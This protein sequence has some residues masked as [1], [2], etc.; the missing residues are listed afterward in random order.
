M[1]I[2][3]LLSILLFSIYSC[4]DNKT[5]N[6]DDQRTEIDLNELARKG[7][8]IALFAQS[9]L[10]TNL[11]RAITADQYAFAVN[12]CH[13]EAGFIMDSV[14]NDGYEVFRISQK[15]RNPLNAANKEEGIILTS[16][17]NGGSDTIIEHKDNYIYYKPIRIGMPV[18]LKCHGKEED[19]DKEALMKINEL[20]PKDKATGYSNAEIRGAWK[21]VFDK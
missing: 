20:Y 7:D 2:A 14:E 21:V 3:I 16:F 8:S 12:Y 4:S 5:S 11:M 6:A 1:K 19:L 9:K 17:Q 15:N 10:V 18:C 13:H